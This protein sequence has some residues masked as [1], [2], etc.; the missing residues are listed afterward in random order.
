[1][2]H[3]HPKL[4]FRRL[5][6]RAA[7][8]FLLPE[9]VKIFRSAQQP[10]HDRAECSLRGALLRA[11]C[12]ARDAHLDR[13]LSPRQMLLRRRQIFRCAAETRQ[14][15]R[16]LFPGTADFQFLAKCMQQKF[17]HRQPLVKPQFPQLRRAGDNTGEHAFHIQL[18]PARCKNAEEGSEGRCGLRLLQKF[19][20]Y[21]I[22]DREVQPF[23]AAQQRRQILPAA[24]RHRAVPMRL[25]TVKPLRLQF[26]KAHDRRVN[27][28]CQR[29]RPPD[30]VVRLHLDQAHA[31]HRRRVEPPRRPVIFRRVA[32]RRDHP[33]LRD[34]VFSKFLLLQ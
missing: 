21:G 24:C 3:S 30:R 33:P 34:T 6:G 10:A 31:I 25:H 29:I 19:S 9:S 12:S 23:I 28:A 14:A 27:A 1:M 7:P 2:L 17:H 26:Q 16:Q 22:L 13:V 5:D 20:E 11:D 15:L 8:R 32:R 18:R 4:R